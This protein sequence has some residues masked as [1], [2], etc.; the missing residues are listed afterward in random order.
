MILGIIEMIIGG[1]GV[2]V[3]TAV[4]YFTTITP[5]NTKRNKKRKSLNFKN[6]SHSSNKI[7]DINDGETDI[8]LN[9]AI[10]DEDRESVV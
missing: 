2:I 7:A 9:N 6:K 3:F 5:I 4:F 8:L 1:V 10:A